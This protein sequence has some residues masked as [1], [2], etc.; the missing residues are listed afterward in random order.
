MD[1]RL[2]CVLG[3]CAPQMPLPLSAIQHPF[4]QE[5]IFDLLT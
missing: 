3:Y 2:L 1:P 5:S 4:P